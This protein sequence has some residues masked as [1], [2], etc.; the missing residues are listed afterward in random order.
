M[1]YVFIYGGSIYFVSIYTDWILYHRDQC[2]FIE[3][4]YSMYRQLLQTCILFKDHQFQSYAFVDVEQ[5]FQ[6][7]GNMSV[8]ATTVA[9]ITSILRHE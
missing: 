8:L 2:T 3:K 1:S 4:Y 5:S 9:A 6:S 7:T